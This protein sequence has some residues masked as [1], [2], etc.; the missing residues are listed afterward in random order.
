MK[1]ALILHGKHFYIN[2]N[3]NFYSK[4]DFEDSN[5]KKKFIRKFNDSTDIFITTNKSQKQ[6]ELIEYF[7]PIYINYK[8]DILNT[9]LENINILINYDI[10]VISKFNLNFKL[11]L[12]FPKYNKNN[13]YIITKFNLII[14]PISKINQ[15]IEFYKN[16]IKFKFFKIKNRIDVINNNKMNIKDLFFI[17]KTNIKNEFKVINIEDTPHFKFINGN[18]EEYINYLKLENKEKHSEE[19]FTNL[20]ENFDIKKQNKITGKVLNNKL[21]IYDGIHRLSILYKKG[22][23]KIKVYSVDKFQ[24]IDMPKH[25]KLIF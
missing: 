16:N 13:T 25:Y 2:K 21:I 18:K 6:N 14:S 8:N 15:I 20:Y 10:I 19:F 9:I 7:K 3:R 12:P 23:T 22:I 17:I 11:R 5:I 1:I 4:I 24:I